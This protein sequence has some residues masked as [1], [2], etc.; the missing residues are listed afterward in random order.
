MKRLDDE[1]QKLFLSFTKRYKGLE[2]MR[3]FAEHVKRCPSCLDLFSKIVVHM[4]KC[5]EGCE[6][7]KFARV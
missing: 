1:K 5:E 3:R 4:D 6:V 2:G 7:K